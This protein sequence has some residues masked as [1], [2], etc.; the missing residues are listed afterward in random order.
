M[1]R[2][3]PI[4]EQPDRSEVPAVP[5]PGEGFTPTGEQKSPGPADTPSVRRAPETEPEVGGADSGSAADLGFR[6]HSLIE[7]VSLVSAARGYADLLR[8]MASEGRKAMEASTASLSVWERDRGRIRTLVNDGDLGPEEVADPVDEVYSLSD[9]PLARRMLADGLG[10]VQT[11][12]DPGADAKIEWILRR[13]GK[14]SCLALP[15]LFEGRVWGEFWVTRAEGMAPFTEA[16]LEFG[17]VVASQV[18]AGIAQAEHLKR[19]ERLAYTDDLTGLANRRGFE[20]RL[21]DALALHR[22]RGTPV[23]VVVVDVNGLKRINDRSGHVAG[24]RAL[25]AFAA[26]LSAAASMVPDTLAARLGGDEF[27]LLAVGSTSDVVVALAQDVCDRA[28]AVLEEG[29]ACGVATTGDLPDVGVTTSRLLR[30]AD[31]AQYRAKR[32]G[33][34]VPVVAG[35]SSAAAEGPADEELP[36][37][38]QFRGRGSSDPGQTLDEV[39][40]RLDEAEDHDPCGRLVAVA[41]VLRESLDAASWFVSVL[42][43]GSSLVETKEHN[44]VRRTEGEDYYVIDTYDV[45]DYPATYAALTGRCIVV[46]ADDPRSDPAEVALLMLGGLSEMVMSGGSDANGDR[47]VVEICGDELSA[48]VR[49]YASVLRA[50]V[51]IALAR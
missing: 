44:V 36:E 16:D 24:D 34:A 46:D 29:V 5:A 21:D 50:G 38:R 9:H 30:A 35:R 45:D 3:P 17:Q 7:F 6:L 11:L 49:S 31:A 4:P 43:A 23:G 22:S 15:I 37:R 27:C 47:W 10:Y 12:G 19:V 51:A 32:S 13:E 26:Q 14:H 41:E 48:P 42:P 8:V 39:L 25:T 1:D 2:T 33:S 28:A 20:D 18:S 40:R